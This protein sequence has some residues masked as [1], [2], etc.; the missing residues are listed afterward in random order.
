M[1]RGT[2]AFLALVAFALLGA[3]LRTA[4][5][6]RGLRAPAME[7]LSFLAIGFALGE[8]VLG[9]FPAD[10][11]ETLRVVVLLG[12]AWIGLVFGLQIELR[13][14]RHLRPWHRR[15][16]WLVP[17]TIGTAV[18]VCGL[19]LGLRPGLVL[20][21]AA[22]AMAPAPS[23]LEG[24]ARGRVPADRSAFRLLKLVMAFAGL[25]AV[26]M[27]GV[28]SAWVSPLS[29]AARGLSPWQLLLYFAGIGIVV[30]Y[31]SLVLVRGVRE[32]VEI[33]TLLIGTMSGL[34]GATALLGV[35]A[36]PAAACSGAVLIN[37]AA[38]PHRILRVAH[39]I[40][41]PLVI[42]LLVL[43]GASWSG[44]A[45]SWQ[46]FSVM[47]VGRTL[48]AL[49][50]GRALAAQAGRQGV[51]VVVP[52]LGLGLLPQ[53]ELALGLLVALVGFSTGSE[54]ILEAVVAAMVIH[55]LVGRWWIRRHLLQRSG[56]GPR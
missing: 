29:D 44:V 10:V 15:V 43:V 1:L 13:V 14:L 34:A 8:R 46:V 30:G 9:L 16:G 41:R 52:G 53:G 37:R 26:A 7:G 38:F 5:A 18:A 24:V 54:G 25:P 22:L 55:Q 19:V 21:L 20:S 51:P 31:L 23:T 50:G 47:V 35:S 12:L 33:V 32:P 56:R 42:A 17:L 3:E 6:R 45:F 27:F 49:V 28:A 39:S 11:L 2:V 36:L 48:G 4:L 40:E